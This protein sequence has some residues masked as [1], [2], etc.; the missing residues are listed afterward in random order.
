MAICSVFSPRRLAPSLLATG[1]ALILVFVTACEESPQ[2]PPE[3]VVQAEPAA[4]EPVG[5]PA[6]GSPHHGRVLTV[7]W[8][9]DDA[10]MTSGSDS[11]R[12][13]NA[14]ERSLVR[15][16]GGKAAQF[17]VAAVDPGGR[18]LVSPTFMAKLRFWD[19]KREQTVWELASLRRRASAV[20]YA[21]G[22][23]AGGGVLGDVAVWRGGTGRAT[24]EAP[25]HEGRVLSVAIDPEAREVV[26]YGVDQKICRAAVQKGSPVCKLTEGEQPRLA[27]G[28]VNRVIAAGASGGVTVFDNKTAQPIAQWSAHD[29]AVSALAYS[30]ERGLVFTAAANELAVWNAE[31]GEQIDTEQTNHVPLAGAV[32]RELDQVAFGDDQGEIYVWEFSLPAAEEAADEAAAAL[33]EPNAAAPPADS[34]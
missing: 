18:I 27:V 5:P 13:W 17:E 33:G 9:P 24:F 20:D 28:S 22:F 29:A 16:F 10:I 34:N 6:F 26:S 11:M 30:E 31:T 23:V 8:L 32:H 15:R 2:A 25:L 14:K 4:L 12:I 19:I 21:G 1:C 7:T 3:P